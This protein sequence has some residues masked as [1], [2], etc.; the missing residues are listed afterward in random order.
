MK[1]HRQALAFATAIL[2]L[3]LFTYTQN[4]TAQEF[5]QAVHQEATLMKP[6][7]AVLVDSLDSVRDQSGHT[8]SAKLQGKVSLSDGTELPRGTVLLGKVTTD[9]TQQQG[10]SKLAL[11]FDQARLKNG[12]TV[13]IRATIVGFY[14]ADAGDIVGRKTLT[15]SQT[16][17]RQRRCNWTSWVLLAASTC[18]VRFPARTQASLSPPEKTTLNSEQAVRFSSPLLLQSNGQNGTT[19]G[20]QS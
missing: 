17:G 16:I 13:P 10:T 6:A 5:K 14:A 18:T 20:G 15:L 2:A 7:S 12:T 4:A 19:A 8:V 3:P 9:D 1:G 11:R